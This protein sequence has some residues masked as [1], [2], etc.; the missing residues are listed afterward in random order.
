MAETVA[1]RIDPDILTIGDLEDFEDTVGVALYDV[2]Q[3]K[4]VI[5]PDGK[6]VLDEKGRPEMQTQI[7]TKALKAL[8]WITQRIDKPEFTLDDARRVRVSELELVGVDDESGND[9][10]QNG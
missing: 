2:L 10:G 4:P 6:K 7:S 8:I 1:L 9:D 5:G 3:P